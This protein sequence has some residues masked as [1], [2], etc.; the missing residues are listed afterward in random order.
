M[1][2]GNIDPVIFEHLQA[3]IDEEG[4]TKDVNVVLSSSYHIAEPSQELKNIVQQL[5]RQGRWLVNVFSGENSH[6]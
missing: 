3:K 5:E 2:S 1:A 4:K 6:S